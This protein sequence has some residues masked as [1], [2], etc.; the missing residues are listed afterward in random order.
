VSAVEGNGKVAHRGLRLGVDVGGTFT[1]FSLVDPASGEVFHFKRSSTPSAP[2][3]ALIEGIKE[4]TAR[5]G[6]EPGQIEYFAHGTTLALNTV[7]QRRG[8]RSALIVSRGNRSVLDIARLR[9]PEQFSFAPTVPP[10]LVPAGMVFE[11]SGRMR[12]S[13]AEETPL[14]AEDVAAAAAWL[15]E[16]EVDACAIALLNSY[17]NPAHERELAKAIRAELGDGVA[18]CASSDLW[19]QYR[20]YERAVVAVL[21]AYVS[22]A[23]DDYLVDLAEQAGAA[24][25]GARLYITK[26]NGGVMGAESARAAPVET[27]LSGPAS[28]VVGAAFTAALADSPNCV[29]FDMGGTSADVSLIVDAQPVHSTEAMV[30][31]YPM[32][33]PSVDVSAI[34]AGGGSIAWIDPYGVLKVGPESA[35]AAPGPACYGLGGSA[36]TV[37]DAYVACGF[38]D[39]DNFLGGEMRLD[40]ELARAA[41]GTLA[42]PLGMSIE[43]A[44]ENVLRVATA[45]MATQFLPLMAQRGIDPRSYAL[46]PYGGAGPTHACLLA[47]E[48]G[49]GRVVVPA[50]PGTLC[51]T[52][53]LINDVVRDYVRA[54]RSAVSALDL[55]ALFARFEE[56]RAEAVAW[57]D[58]EPIETVSRNLLAAAD[59]RYRGQA[60]DVEVALDLGSLKTVDDLAEAFHARHEAIYQHCDRD[61]S[62]E[63]LSLRM[64]IVGATPGIELPPPASG[65]GGAPSISV[66]R[67]MLVGGEAH[68]AAIVARSEL[69]AGA[70]LA[71]PAVV[72]QPDTTVPVPPGWTL[73]VHRHGV[74]VIDRDA[75]GE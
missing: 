66:R 61:A 18:V 12:A 41:L 64:R 2:A 39:P 24:G 55:G 33:M 10:P 51:A 40:R 43:Q 4:L 19:P 74:L 67:Q 8:A 50:S 63:L 14:A 49:I 72:E 26:S 65:D 71:G 16:M 58:S 52:G 60:Y 17:A 20:E 54:M 32:V 47:E 11:V 5:H 75:E 70:V 46:L 53:A 68:E 37:T 6:L 28:G 38:L 69:G 45:N 13:G 25:L 15:R 27:L 23:M 30:G 57:L 7:I 1:D 3:E 42:E 48:V 36:P 21:N 73:T 56:M 31:D 35:G 9:V 34:G 29:T 59:M 44:A 62:V 22:P